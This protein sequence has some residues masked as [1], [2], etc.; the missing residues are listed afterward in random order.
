MQA[1]GELLCIVA[2]SISNAVRHGAATEVGIRLHANNGNGLALT[3]FDNGRGF[4]P[5]SPEITQGGLGLAGMQTRVER[6]GGH[7]QLRSQPG[8]GTTVEV[9]LP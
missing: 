7:F 3:I 8:S 1:R 2:E 9:A 5:V 4:D 6:L